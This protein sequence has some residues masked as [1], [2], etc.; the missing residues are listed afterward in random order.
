MEGGGGPLSGPHDWPTHPAG[1]PAV[2][3]ALLPRSLPCAF[4][5]PP[6]LPLWVAIESEGM[7]CRVRTVTGRKSHFNSRMKAG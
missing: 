2:A 1:R 6:L 4:S 5:L 3:V 7:R